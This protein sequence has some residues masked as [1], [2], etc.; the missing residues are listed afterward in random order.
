MAERTRMIHVRMPESLVKAVDQLVKRSSLP[1]S[2]SKFVVEAVE[3]SLRREHYISAVKG[4]A[5]ILATEDV[6]HW[7]DEKAVDSWLSANREAD[8]KASEEKW[9]P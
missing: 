6:P 7:K 5:G 1:T 8:E 3:K 2:R 9:Q 4:L